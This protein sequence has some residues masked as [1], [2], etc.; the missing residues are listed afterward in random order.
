M[1]RIIDPAGRG[2]RAMLVMAA[3]TVALALGAC[4]QAPPP[5]PHVVP[6]GDP[7]RG[8]RLVASYGCGSC[9]VVPG[10]PGARGRVGPSLDGFARRSYIAGALRNEPVT[11]VRWIRAPQQVDPGTVMPNLGVTEPHARD[12]AAYLYT[13]GADGLGPPHLVSPHALPA[14]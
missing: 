6:G 5:D 14:H 2:L 8:R 3:C 12:I 10:V 11:L 13:L 7:G 1:S 9:H 4:R